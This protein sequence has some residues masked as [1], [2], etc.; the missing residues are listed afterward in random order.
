MTPI[1]QLLI[2]FIAFAV[3]GALLGGVALWRQQAAQERRR[4]E[5]VAVILRAMTNGALSSLED[6]HALAR[7]HFGT[8]VQGL[9]ALEDISQQLRE[10]ML[11][12]SS[13]IGASSRDLGHLPRLRELLTEND[14]RAKQELIRV[15]F[16][17]TPSPER[18][19]LEDILE[20]TRSDREHVK[21]KLSD[22]AT[23]IRVR[24]ETI[25]RL[26]AESHQSLKWAKWGLAGTVIFSVISIALVIWPIR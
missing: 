12:I 13:S 6:L 10:A 9:H 11:I 17:G 18:Q 2:T 23:A 24:Q 3:V 19:L 8:R 25:E 22:L 5:F 7:A 21:A 4:K 26:G 1:D 14:I 15:P 20:L 16:F